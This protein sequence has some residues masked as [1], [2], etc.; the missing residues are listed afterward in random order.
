MRL[1]ALE[2]GGAVLGAALYEDGRPLAS[3]H[4][5]ALQRQAET[6]APLVQQLLA[7]QGW[8]AGDLGAVACG[9][10][11]GSFT[12]LR[13]SLAFGRGLQLGVPGLQLV[14]VPT[15]QAWAEAFAPQKEEVVVLLDGRRGQVYRARLR[16]TTD[17]WQNV[18]P[19]ALV[20]LKDAMAELQGAGPAAAAALLSDLAPER[21]APLAPLHVRLE[22]PGLA[23]AVGRL[24]LKA[25]EAGVLPDW[26]PLYLRRSEAEILWDKLHPKA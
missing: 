4:Q 25:L 6:L 23:L 9:L 3:V 26:E 21:L 5:G 14:G 12:G 17:A 11:P 18:M 16:R 20:D 19:S 8:K 1:L 2:A 22:S 24:G 10:G 7:G 13:S 15:L